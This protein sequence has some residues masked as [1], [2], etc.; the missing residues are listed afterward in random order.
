MFEYIEIIDLTRGWFPAPR[1]IAHMKSS[2]LV[3]CHINIGY[4]VSFGD[5]LVID[6]IHDLNRR[7]VDSPAQLVSLRNACK[8]KTGM[9]P[10]GIEWLNNQCQTFLFNNISAHLQVVDHISSLVVTVQ[11]FVVPAG[12]NQGPLSTCSECSFNPLLHFCLQ[13]ILHLRFIEDE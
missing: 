1:V 5:L 10:Y 4:Y 11:P 2:Y 13:H 3:P 8:E 7:S 12:H 9:I 6:I